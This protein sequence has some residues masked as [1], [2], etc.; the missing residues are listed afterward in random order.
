[1]AINYS[2]IGWDTTKYVNPTN[3]NQMDNGIKA[4]CDGVDAIS[5]D[6]YLER[7]TAW[8]S[9]V[10]HSV[11][12]APVGTELVFTNHGAPTTGMLL[13]VAGAEADNSKNFKWQ[14][15]S[16]FTQTKIYARSRNGGTGT[17]AAWKEIAFKDDFGFVN[18]GATMTATVS[19]FESSNG[20]RWFRVPIPTT[21]TPT[22]TKVEAP[23]GTDISSRFNLGYSGAGLLAA[24]TWDTSYDNMTLLV[25][26]NF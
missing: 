10:A 24:Y 25:T 8:G 16:D 19:L 4:A 18:S 5:G 13:T 6:V 26:F 9:T 20:A 12:D 22:I 11:D 21:K 23:G 1:M 17:W 14:M 7:N 3:M 2:K 15:M